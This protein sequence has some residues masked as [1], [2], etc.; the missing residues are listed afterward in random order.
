MKPEHWV[1]NC[2]IRIS[3]PCF[4]WGS[5]RMLLCYSFAPF[6]FRTDWRQNIC[7]RKVNSWESPAVAMLLRKERPRAFRTGNPL[8]GMKSMSSQGWKWGEHVLCYGS[9]WLKTGGVRV[10]SYILYIYYIYIYICI[11]TG[12]IQFWWIKLKVSTLQTEALS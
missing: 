8:K 12:I 10:T 5:L 4:G 6:Q 9:I 7:G 1:Y 2:F 11:Y 3:H